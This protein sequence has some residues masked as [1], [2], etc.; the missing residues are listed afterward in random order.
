MTK[1]KIKIGFLHNTI[2]LDEKLLMNVADKYGV[3][4]DAIDIRE[5]ILDPFHYVSQYDAVLQRSLSAVKGM[6]AIEFFESIGV[7]VV[8]TLSVA[9]IC[10]NKFLTSLKLLENHVPTVPFLM[11]FGEK[12]AKRA[13]ELLGGFPVVLKP[14]SG[15]WGRLVSR[16]NDTDALEGLIEQKMVLGGPHQQALYFQKYIDK[17][18]RDIRIV[19]IGKQVIAAMYRKSDHWITNTA[20][21]AQ[22]YSCTVDTGLSEIALKTANAVG[23]GILG[24]DI[25]ETPDGYLVNE[26]NHTMEFKN[27]QRVTG[28]DVAGE[29]IQYCMKVAQNEK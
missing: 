21:G 23:E 15:S 1:N 25:F 24:I 27:V 19:V 11:V 18:G 6:H 14:V 7:P 22:A 29:I 16:I 13:V 2:R 5:E 8:N 4:L 28:I 26:V 12:E 10:E 17:P 3:V 20:R 9:R